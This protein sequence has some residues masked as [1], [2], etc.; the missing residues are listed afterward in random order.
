MNRKQIGRLGLTKAI[1]YFTEKGY[2]ISIPLNDTQWYDLI[3]EKNGIFQAVQC[4]ATATENDEIDIRSTGGT[5]GGVYDSILNHPNLAYIFCVN[6]DLNCW[7]IPFPA[8]KESGIVNKFRLRKALI[9]GAR[10]KL[11]TTPYFVK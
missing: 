1:E 4:K 2:S 10:P 9:P 8:L 7:N 11:D 6:K 3:I 5:D